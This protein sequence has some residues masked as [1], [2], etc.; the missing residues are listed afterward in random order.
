MSDFLTVSD[1]AEAAGVSKQ[2]VY[3]R[4]TGDLAPYCKTEGGRR[5]IDLV[6]V[7]LFNPKNNR[8]TTG[9]QVEQRLI[10]DQLQEKDEMIERQREEIQG[11]KAQIADLQGHV[12]EQSRTLADALT[13]QTAALSDMLDKQ[14]TLQENFQI[15][16]GQHQKIL[17]GLSAPREE[18]V[19][20]EQPT[21]N[22]ETT[23]PR[24]E[25]Q[26][27]TVDQ[28]K[29]GGFFARLLGR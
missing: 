29:K 23:S 1:F 21:D 5:L 24:V 11:L 3:K 17:E 16:L 28:P 25:Q 7:E 20:V 10:A 26:K 12:I 6:A 2:A 9:P 22:P 27:P 8:G 15:L 13:N 18:S 4:M 19:P 14:T